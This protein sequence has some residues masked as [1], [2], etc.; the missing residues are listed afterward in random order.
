MLKLYSNLLGVLRLGL[1]VAIGLGMI[2]PVIL[3]PSLGL[4]TGEVAGG[5]TGSAAAPGGNCGSNRSRFSK[6][7]I[8][9]MAREIHADKAECYLKLYEAET[10]TNPACEQTQVPNPP[11]IGICTLEGDPNK[12]KARGGDCAV[13]DLDGNTDVG[14]KN[15]MKCCAH[16]M[17][18]NGNQYF[19]PVKEGKVQNCEGGGS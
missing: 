2:C 18:E 19:Q 11:G 5:D 15:Q 13:D 10:S 4:A 3:L 1:P 9:T 8:E 6:S 12:R 17:K 14:V 7:E 16:I